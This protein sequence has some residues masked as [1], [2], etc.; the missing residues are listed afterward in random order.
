MEVPSTPCDS[1]S[2]RPSPETPLGADGY[3]WWYFDGVSFDGEVGITLIAMLGNV[4]SPYYAHAR[5]LGP[6]DP[7]DFPAFNVVLYR[8]WGKRWAL[9][10]YPRDAAV[11]TSTTLRIGDN[12]LAWEHGRVDIYIDEVAVPMGGKIR[13]KVEL[14]W[15]PVDCPDVALDPYGRHRWFP[16]APVAKVRVLLQEPRISFDGLGYHDA[17]IGT[18]PLERCFDSWSWSRLSTSD[19]TGVLYDVQLRGAG[20]SQRGWV[21]NAT[22]ETDLW[23]AEQDTQ[24]GKTAW[25]M[26]RPTR[27]EGKVTLVRG[28]ED[29]PFYTRSLITGSVQGHT[30]YGMHESLSLRRFEAGW[31][32]WLLP[33]KMRRGH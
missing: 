19:R 23:R 10:E 15:D 28:L 11:R 22:G 32:R 29:T 31:V 27:G 5:R 30:A 12:F 17:N 7:L 4:F 21:F 1:M 24:L 33:F 14:S 25:Q 3:G 2:A 16:V 9:T 20:S 6:T 13:G 26:Q 18:Q 8:P